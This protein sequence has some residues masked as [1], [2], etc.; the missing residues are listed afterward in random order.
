MVTGIFVVCW[1]PFFLVIITFTFCPTSSF[2]WD[3]HVLMS[4]KLLHY[5]NS[6]CNPIVYGVRNKRFNSAFREILRRLCCRK[7]PLYREE[8]RGIPLMAGMSQKSQIRTRC[9]L[10]EVERKPYAITSRRGIRDSI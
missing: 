7:S 6:G 3:L 10:V 2:V 8:T 4:V 5:G 1:L 9:T